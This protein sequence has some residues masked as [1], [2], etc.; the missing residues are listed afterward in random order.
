MSQ[1]G[2]FQKGEELYDI[3]AD[4]N[5]THAI[6]YKLSKRLTTK[7]GTDIKRIATVNQSDLM[8]I[9]IMYHIAQI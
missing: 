8:V 3:E 6:K 1:E 2:S 9:I 4:K 7:I 5:V